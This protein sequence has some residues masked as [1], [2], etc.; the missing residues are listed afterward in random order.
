MFDCWH[1]DEAFLHM[2][3]KATWAAE[4]YYILQ[5]L[6]GD[7]VLTAPL[8]LIYLFIHVKQSQYCV[9]NGLCGL[10]NLV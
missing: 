2:L 3:T 10:L 5:R 9:E 8:R 4:A 1:L 7:L 6:S